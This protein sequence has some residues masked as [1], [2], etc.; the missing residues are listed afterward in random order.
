[1]ISSIVIGVSACLLGEYVRYDGGHKRSGY[2]CD[3][4]GR[5]FS[6][7]P[8]CP[9]AGCGLPI[10]REPMRLEGDPD[11]PRL[12]TCETRSDKT[13]QMMRY[14]T[15]KMYELEKAGL[16]GFI[17]KERSPSCGLGTVPLYRYGASCVSSATGLFAREI[18]RAFPFLPLEEVER[19][20]DPDIRQDFLHRVFHYRRTLAI[21]ET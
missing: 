7:M 9:E 2:I 4:L 10:P 5:H 6:L 18:S 13:E 16:C 1:M 3:I 15:E 14:C 19:L 17:F 8:V 12:M 21:P 20:N 11:A